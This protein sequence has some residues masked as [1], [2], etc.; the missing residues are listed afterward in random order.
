MTSPVV[1]RYEFRYTTINTG[2]QTSF[3]LGGITEN[4][5]CGIKYG[6][7][8]VSEIT[9]VTGLKVLEATEYVEIGPPP[10]PPTH[11]QV[12]FTSASLVAAKNQKVYSYQHPM[13]AA[14][15]SALIV[16]GTFWTENT[17]PDATYVISCNGT[18][19]VS[20]GKTDEPT[21]PFWVEAYTLLA[22]PA[23]D[24]TIG[25]D[26][27]AQAGNISARLQSLVYTGVA[28]IG[29]FFSSFGNDASPVMT[30]LGD[31]GYLV[32]CAFG[33]D[34][35]PVAVPTYPSQMERGKNSSS[36]P[37]GIETQ[38]GL[39]TFSV[40]LDQPTGWAGGAVALIPAPLP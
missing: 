2:Q 20:K 4:V 15:D 30:T 7:E 9:A 28:E 23:G 19:M 24:A 39:G 11:G 26:F 32:A 27:S 25:W 33:F 22:P 31:A 6:L 21:T 16:L 40:N 3:A 38:D 36:T 34:G 10:Q 17:P 5:A 12:K 14:T 1:V 37:I 8:T 13:P 18:P 35:S 29:D